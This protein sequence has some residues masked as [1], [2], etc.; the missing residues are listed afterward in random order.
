M[1]QTSRQKLFQLSCFPGS[2]PEYNSNATPFLYSS[3][4][5][6]YTIDVSPSVAEGSTGPGWHV[7]SAI[8]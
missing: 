7:T 2:H 6:G 3:S 4:L 1:R 8:E 5:K